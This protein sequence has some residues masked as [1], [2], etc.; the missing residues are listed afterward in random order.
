MKKLLIGLTLLA[1]MSSFA[2]QDENIKAT[3]AKL[4][5][6]VS[7][8]SNTYI[9]EVKH[10]VYSGMLQAG[11][12]SLVRGDNQEEVMMHTCKSISGSRQIGD[13]VALNCLSRYSIENGD[14]RFE[15]ARAT[16]P[17]LNYQVTKLAKCMLENY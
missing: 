7:S 13:L 14:S 4:E 11:V 1:S 12:T 6:V 2:N 8:V 3:I 17:Q 10:R 9:P 16:C 15:N 5:K